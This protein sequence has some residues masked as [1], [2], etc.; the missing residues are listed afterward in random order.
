[1]KHLVICLD[2]T[3][4]DG[5]PEQ[6][7]ALARLAIADGGDPLLALV[8]TLIAR[9]QVAKKAFDDGADLATLF[10]CASAVVAAGNALIGAVPKINYKAINL[11]YFNRDG[12]YV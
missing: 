2:G 10:A 6:S 12:F 11:R 9:V 7:L 8:D 1:M 5:D 4:S 3:W